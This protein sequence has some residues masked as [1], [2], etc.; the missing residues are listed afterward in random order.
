MPTAGSGSRLGK[1]R[2][3]YEEIRELEPLNLIALPLNN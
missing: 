1:A 2:P 3:M